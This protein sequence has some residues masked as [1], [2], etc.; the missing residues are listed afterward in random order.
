MKFF[1]FVNIVLQY[2]PCVAACNRIW[3]QRLR[4]EY[5]LYIYVVYVGNYTSYEE[6]N[7]VIEESLMLDCLQM[8]LTS[9]DETIAATR[10]NKAITSVVLTLTSKP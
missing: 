5:A 3:K 9:D 2:P 6:S 4:S 1:K 8:L 7:F 10:S